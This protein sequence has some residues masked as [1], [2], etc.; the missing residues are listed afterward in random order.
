MGD[1]KLGVALRRG[2][3]KV[4]GDPEL[5]RRLEELLV[6]EDADSHSYVGRRPM[7]PGAVA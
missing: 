5:A 4:E 6:F 1:T 2:L 3:V 7:E